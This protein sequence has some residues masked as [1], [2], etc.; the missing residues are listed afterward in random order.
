MKFVLVIFSLLLVGCFGSNPC[1]PNTEYVPIEKQ[2][3]V[4]TVPDNL[5][6]VTIPVRPQL[7]IYTLQPTDANQPDLV[8]K[9][10]LLTISQLLQYTE[11]LESTISIYQLGL[12][13]AEQQK[14]AGKK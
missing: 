10:Q 5:K 4:F 9:K 1:K 13:D 12:A 11:N 14:T 3:Q 8:V 6:N 7:A 2:V